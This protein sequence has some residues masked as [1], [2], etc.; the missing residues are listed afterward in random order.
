MLDGMLVNDGM[1]ESSVIAPFEPGTLS[2]YAVEA[3]I[4]YVR[5]DNPWC[6]NSFGLFARDGDSGGYY[7]AVCFEGEFEVQAGWSGGSDLLAQQTYALDNEWHTYR[8]EVN[9][10]QVRFLVDGAILLSFN[11]N[12]MLDGGSVGLFVNGYQVNVRAFRVIALGEAEAPDS[13]GEDGGNS[14]AIADS[15]PLAS[16]GEIH[17]DAKDIAF[18][19]TELTIHAEDEPVTIKLKNTGAALHTFSIDSLK[20]DVDVSPGETVDVVIPKGTAPGTYEFYC[21]IPGHKE[22]GM[23]G[24][25]VVT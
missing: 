21:D 1:T 8:L 12:R 4:Q 6:P 24:T 10:N 19:P 22:A 15:S 18:V 17:L 9:G 13:V 5:S 11:D 3:E 2:D 14:G 23:V 20:I 25:M 7:G 16:A